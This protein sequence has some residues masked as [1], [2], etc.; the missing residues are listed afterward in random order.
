MDSPLFRQFACRLAPVIA[1]WSRQANAD[2]A[3]GDFEPQAVLSIIICQLAQFRKFGSV[4]T[5][6]LLQL[7]VMDVDLRK[8]G[9]GVVITE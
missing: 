5:Q 8:G 2:P 1:V 6:P 3:L 9:F 7:G 4:V